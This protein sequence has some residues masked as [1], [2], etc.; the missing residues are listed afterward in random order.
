[1]ES[2]GPAP[3]ECDQ[4]FRPLLVLPGILAPMAKVMI[5]MP[6]ELLARVDGEAH[7]RGLSRSAMLRECVSSLLD[8]RSKLLAERMREINSGARPNRGGT[9]LEA[10]KADRRR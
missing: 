10:L 9:G 2:A 7:R 1:M 4:V 8:Q 6:D 5:S 3:E